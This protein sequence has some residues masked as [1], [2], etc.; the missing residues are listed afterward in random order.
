ML[1]LIN[2]LL[3]FPRYTWA[4]RQILIEQYLKLISQLQA[5]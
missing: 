4:I 3:I 1:L 5:M 2:F